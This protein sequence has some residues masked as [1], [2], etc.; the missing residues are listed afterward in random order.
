[1]ITRGFNKTLERDK[2][3]FNNQY[4]KAKNRAEYLK[5]MKMIQ[6]LVDKHPLNKENVNINFLNRQTPID[7]KMLN[8]TSN[9]NLAAW[10][11][12]M[13]DEKF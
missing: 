4:S 6:K 10:S 9:I 13:G 7:D 8:S 5:N 2:Q 1:M 11:E 3:I 12:E